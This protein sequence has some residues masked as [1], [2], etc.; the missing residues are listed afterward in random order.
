MKGE[1]FV[2]ESWVELQEVLYEDSWTP[3]LNRFRSSYVYRGME[4]VAYDLSTSLNRLG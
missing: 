1:T 2:V 3:D 4:D